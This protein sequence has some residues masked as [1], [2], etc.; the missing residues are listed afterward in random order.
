[1]KDKC[2]FT[3]CARNYLAQALT[4]RESFIKNNHSIDF[5]I[6]IADTFEDVQED[7]FIIKLDDSWLPGWKAMAFKYNVIEFSTSIKPFCI[8]FLFKTYNNV[9]YLDPDIYVI[10]NLTYIFDKLKLKDIF[11]TP[12]YLSIEENYTGAVTE[13]E[14]LFVGIYNLGFL[15][16]RNSQIG[17]KVVS[18]WMNRLRDKCYADKFDGLHV[19]QKWFDFIPAYFPNNVEI[20]HH[21]GINTAIWNLHERTLLEDS[22]QYFV[23]NNHT[24]EKMDLLFF[25]FSG[26]NPRNPAVINRRHPRYNIDT[27]PSFKNIFDEYADAVFAHN[28]LQYTEMPYGFNWFSNFEKIIPFQRR[29]FR[30]LEA[31]M[32]IEDPFESTGAFY[33]LL[34]SNKLLT[35]DR[36]KKIGS[37]DPNVLTSNSSGIRLGKMFLKFLKFALPL[38]H[39][40]NILV[41][42]SE[43]YRAEKSVFLIKKEN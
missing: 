20:S 37:S 14:I 12:H 9:V 43:Y 28:Y 30:V 26:F 4:L 16:I 22:G 34:R 42:F 39:Y 41:F 33:R 8:H 21:V 32:N 35:H 6:F 29:I 3:V 19:D 38:R 2:V 24:G 1:M 15:G 18:W 17:N 25:H 31:E 40:N 13:E 11:I 5:F 7:S 23:I 10:N 27:F 36:V